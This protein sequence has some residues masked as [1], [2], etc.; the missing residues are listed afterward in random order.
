MP[1]F[2]TPAPTPGTAPA[3]AARSPARPAPVPALVALAIGLVLA[4]CAPAPSTDA[5]PLRP[6]FTDPAF[7]ARVTGYRDITV[8][9]RTGSGAEAEPLSAA[10]CTLGNAEMSYPPFTAPAKVALPKITGRPDPLM[11]RC[12]QGDLR[13]T[14]RLD[15]AVDSRAPL[16][17]TP[18]GVAMA[19]ANYAI[20]S[21]QDRWIHYAWRGALHVTLLPRAAATTTAEP[22]GN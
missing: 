3:R 11:L 21:S 20:A 9:P 7:E 14:V 13:T 17:P 4:G 18:V 2:Q 5:P 12:E 16:L 19:G 1:H 15:P 8:A 22:T 10:A 6:S